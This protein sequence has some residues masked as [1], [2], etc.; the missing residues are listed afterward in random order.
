M[1]DTSGK[2]TEVKSKRPPMPAH[3]YKIHIDECVLCGAGGERRERMFTPKPT[4]PAARYDYEQ[5]AC[6]VH[7]C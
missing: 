4:D 1:S 5:R 2:P 7:F 3:W 6:G